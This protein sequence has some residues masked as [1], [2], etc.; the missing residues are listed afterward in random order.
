MQDVASRYVPWMIQWRCELGVISR[1][2]GR[3]LAYRRAESNIFMWFWNTCCYGLLSIWIFSKVSKV[4]YYR[5][6]ALFPFT[7]HEFSKYCGYGC[8]ADPICIY[9]EQLVFYSWRACLVRSKML[10]INLF[11]NSPEVREMAWVEYAFAIILVKL[12]AYLQQW[13]NLWHI[14][15]FIHKHSS[16]CMSLSL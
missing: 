12:S 11:L 7:I 9:A 16:V 2:V 5:I 3:E 13:T 14:L 8:M 6:S 4:S 15:A 10:G 1:F